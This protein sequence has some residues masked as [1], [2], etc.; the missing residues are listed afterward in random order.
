MR[1]KQLAFM[2]VRRIDPQLREAVERASHLCKA[3]LV[4]GMVGEFPK[5]QGIVGGSMP[6]WPKKTGSLGGDL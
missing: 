3:D 6:V 4:T 1:F 5:L 2:V